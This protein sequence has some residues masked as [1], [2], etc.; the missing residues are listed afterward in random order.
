MRGFAVL[1][2]AILVFPLAP[3]T[4]QATDT[5]TFA[6]FL[7]GENGSIFGTELK[8]AK[9]PPYL[10]T[11]FDTTNS[12]EVHLGVRTEDYSDWYYLD[13]AAPTGVDLAVG[14]YEGATREA[15]HA[16]D[17]PGMD[18][19]GN[20]IGCNT[21]TGRFEVLEVTFDAE[22]VLHHL[23]IDFEHH[24]EG[25]PPALFGGI[26][27]DSAIALRALDLSAMS[28]DFGS[29]PIGS[30][31]ATQSVI[32]SNTGT[33]PLTVSASLAGG[34][35]GDFRIVSDGCT[36]AIAPD[37]DC[38]IGVAFA[39]TTSG[40]RSATLVLDDDTFRGAHAVALGGTGTVP[41]SGVW[42]TPDGVGPGYT[43]NLGNGLARTVSSGTEYLHTHYTT[44]RI[45]G[46]WADDDGPRVGVYYVRYR[47]GTES[48]PYRLNPTS[49]HG[50]R[51]A[52]A[53]AGSRVYTTWVSFR[54][55]EDYDPGDPRV[56]YFRRNSSHGSAGYW[57][58]N[59]RL[60]SLSGR[61]D[62]PTVAASGTSVYV[63][64][65]NS[66][67]GAIRLAISR[68]RG[69][70]WTTRTIG[71]TTRTRAD[72]KAGIPVVVAAGTNVAVV[73][74]ANGN[75]AVKT[76]LSTDSGVTWGSSTP[77][78]LASSSFYVADA[79]ARGSRI[80]FSWTTASGVKMKI[81]QAGSWQDTRTVASF[82]STGTYKA[83]YA[84]SV[85]LT[86]TSGVGVAWAACRYSDCSADSSRGV[87]LA[88]RES[89]TNGATWNGRVT[90]A[91][92]TSG[93][94]R[95]LDYPSVVWANSSRR[96]VLY[97]ATTYSFSAYRLYI[98]AGESATSATASLSAGVE[99]QADAG[100]EAGGGPSALRR[101]TGPAGPQ[102]R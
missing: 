95:F 14:A 58:S 15:F 48:T 33:G 7:D 73:W 41:P 12:E 59:K 2:A 52:I 34:H 64:Y 71:T 56:L 27:Y 77:I 30:V 51:G 92:S 17:E 70:T 75:N 89:T 97:N 53:S 68:D 22:G 74:L 3:T 62:W 5:G 39:P 9:S 38:S 16:P 76:R 49:Q 40:A 61:V 88:W 72:G 60:T 32:V 10:F 19:Y 100:S 50:G 86:G 47:A 79:D 24:C 45:G 25:G 83:G 4:A 90:L 35:P 66:D 65:T 80:A 18:I 84:P 81:W 94:W 102:E 85:A 54:S 44:N 78:T 11:S 63:A 43:W 31:S 96:Y 6:L 46:S 99:S 29:Q 42:S 87:D 91:N 13:F 93:S 82:S 23:A 55:E 101:S 69:A 28:V 67:T 26:R 57:S 36:T 8:T 98:R 1:V 37:T 21:V 20:G